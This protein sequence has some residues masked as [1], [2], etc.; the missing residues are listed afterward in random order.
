MTRDLHEMHKGKRYGVCAG[1]MNNVLRDWDELC[2]R[3]CT[4]F[5]DHNTKTLA[6]KSRLGEYVAPERPHLNPKLLNTIQNSRHRQRE[7]RIESDNCDFYHDSFDRRKKPTFSR[8]NRNQEARDW[9]VRTTQPKYPKHLS[10][11]GF[12]SEIRLIILENIFEDL[13]IDAWGDIPILRARYG[14]WKPVANP[15]AILLACRELYFEGHKIFQE[16]TTFRTRLIPREDCMGWNHL[17]FQNLLPNVKKLQIK[18]CNP[19]YYLKNTSK[20]HWVHGWY[21]RE[22]DVLL[23]SQADEAFKGDNQLEKLTVELERGKGRSTNMSHYFIKKHA[24]DSLTC[25][26]GKVKMMRIQGEIPE[27]LKVYARKMEILVQGY[28]DTPPPVV[29]EE[30]EEE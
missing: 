10:L 27:A 17:G 22:L 12:P 11:M 24:V 21:K 30:V 5:N 7:T 2:F 14:P 28:D 1:S 23:Q 13:E 8:G 19:E 26:L 29:I 6:I 20:I 9:R 4:V 3:M 15:L 16:Q 25:F 18:I